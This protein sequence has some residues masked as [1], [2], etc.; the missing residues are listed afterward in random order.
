MFGS[1]RSDDE[2]KRLGKTWF[3]EARAKSEKEEAEFTTWNKERRKW[4][5]LGSRNSDDGWNFF[6]SDSSFGGGDS[7]GGFG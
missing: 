6:G 4:S 7:G 5:P 3:A 1:K 2:L